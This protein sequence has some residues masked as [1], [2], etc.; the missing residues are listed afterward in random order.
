[1]SAFLLAAKEVSE[2]EALSIVGWIIVIGCI[3]GAI[4]VAV[5]RRD[6]IVPLVLIAI[7]IVAAWLLL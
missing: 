7:A 3:I 2:N 6:W 4:V 5:T 1:M